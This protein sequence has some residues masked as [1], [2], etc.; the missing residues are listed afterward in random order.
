M[1]KKEER[2]KVSENFYL[3]EFICKEIYMQI[4]YPK[5]QEILRTIKEKGIDSLY[6]IIRNGEKLKR[7]I[8]IAQFCR[9][10]YNVS[11]TINN[12]AT[13]GERNNSGWRDQN[14]TVGAKLSAHKNCEAIDIVF[15]NLDEKDVFVDVT[16][17][18]S[19]FFNI[20]VREIE[21]GTY[22]ED[23][24]EGWTHLSIR[25]FSATIVIVPFWKKKK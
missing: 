24:G 13:G 15:Q 10:R 22:N 16:T 25:G 19:T 6:L 18:K 5:T 9:S 17:N 1:L 3:D 23:T 2:I 11:A 7:L 12:W 21:Q 8:K 20:G 4:V 14:S